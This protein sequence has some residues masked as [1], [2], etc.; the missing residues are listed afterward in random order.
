MRR[1]IS[2]GNQGKQGGLFFSIDNEWLLYGEWFFDSKW[3]MINYSVLEKS[4]IHSK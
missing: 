2:K 4:S 1:I 3:S